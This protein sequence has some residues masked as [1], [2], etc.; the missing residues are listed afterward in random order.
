[1]RLL[2]HSSASELRRVAPRLHRR[3]WLV[4]LKRACRTTR[5]QIGLGIT[6]LVVLIAVVGAF[7]TPHSPTAFMVASFAPPSSH[8]LLGGDTLGRDVLSRVLAG[9]WVLMLMALAATA[10]GVVFG[11]INGIEAAYLGGR[12]DSLIMRSRDVFLAFP[13]VVLALLL[14]STVGPKLWLII[15]AVGLGHVPQVSRVIRG[16]ALDL[17]ERD[18]VKS[19]ELMGVK[20]MRIMTREILP[21]LVSPLMVELGLRLTFSI[22][23]IAS[24]SFLG[25]GQQPPAPSWGIMINEN[26]IGLQSNP[27][28]VIVPA[29]LIALLTI[30]ANTFTDAVARVAIGAEGRGVLEETRST[31]AL[32]AQT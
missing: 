13:Q 21:N 18:Y 20:P 16:A 7:W 31:M 26:R 17:S 4:I 6:T 22:I 11:A 29:A 8:A 9:G 15:L 30:G 12:T 10:I 2:T 25:F 3:E 5:G 24:L 27:W 23:V 19:V 32:G 14:V 1:V 28:A